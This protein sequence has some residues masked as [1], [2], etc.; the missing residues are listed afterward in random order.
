MS[1]C[2]RVKTMLCQN[3]VVPQNGIVTTRN[4]VNATSHQ[5]DVGLKKS[6]APTRCR[7]NTMP[8]QKHCRR[9]KIESCQHGSVS[10]RHR[11]SAMPCQNEVAS[12]Q[13]R[14]K[15]APCQHDAVPIRCLFK[16]DAV[17]TRHPANM[18]SCRSDGVSLRH[19]VKTAS[20]Q[21]DVVSETAP[22]EHDVVSR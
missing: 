13:H 4:R 19:D 20:C 15:T 12:T 6:I 3:G 22:C 1:R 7:V 11:A 5:R 2:C 16:N 18:T 8:C 14:I 9:I 17:S 10:R 21:E